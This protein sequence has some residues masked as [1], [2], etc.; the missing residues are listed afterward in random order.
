M[1]TS[2][3][4]IERFLETRKLAIAGVSRD[5]KKFGNMIYKEM[6]DL[7]MEVCPVNPNTGQIN[8]E[9]CYNS[10]NELPSGI[11]YLLV[12]TPKSRTLDTVRE[13]VG[14]GIENIWIQQ[15]SET[16]EVIDYLK[17]KPV[18]VVTHECIFMWLEPVKSIHK[19]HRAI[20]KFFGRLPK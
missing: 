20:R 14:K 6:K 10:V 2:R 9:K 5:P 1:K 18:K 16:R 4:S 11:G 3:Q 19:F 15:S 13:A 12:V 17:D 8:G 7:G